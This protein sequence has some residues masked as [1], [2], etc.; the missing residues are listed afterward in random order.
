M[1]CGEK[2]E[3]GE[4]RSDDGYDEQDAKGSSDGDAHGAVL[5]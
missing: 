5:N 3:I 2:G 1:A 4:G